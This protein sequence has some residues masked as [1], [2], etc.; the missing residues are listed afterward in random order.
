MYIYNIYI[1]TYICICIYRR[2]CSTARDCSF[3][4]TPA[5]IKAY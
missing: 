1:H 5:V 3:L 2:T 4:S